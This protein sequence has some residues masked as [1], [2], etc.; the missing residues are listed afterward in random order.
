M[1]VEVTLDQRSHTPHE[2]GADRAHP[3]GATVDSDGTN[4]SVFA[5]DAD[6]VELLLFDS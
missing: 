4:F 2:T 6:R 5:L 3:P 1:T